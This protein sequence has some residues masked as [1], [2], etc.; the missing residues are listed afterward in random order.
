[1][2]LKFDAILQSEQA[3]YLDRLLPESQEILAE[4]ERFAEENGVPIAD[5]EVA[6]FLEI[7]A[8][9]IRA[10]RCLEIGMAI[11]YGA[12]HLARGI[13]EQGKVFTI[14]PSD[15]MIALGENYL[16]KLNLREKVEIIKGKALDIMPNIEGK[17]DLLY[18]D[19]VKEEYAEYLELG[20][21][22]LRAGG[23]VIADNLLWGGRVAGEIEDEKQ[24]ASTFALRN[25]NEIFVNHPQLKAQILSIGDG[26]GYGVK[27]S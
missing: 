15:Q 18:L 21:P 4:M 26:L 8:R 16:Q 9:A 17:F 3:E 23:I 19:A 27:I 2:K 20:L 22:L 11:G 24:I 7:T 25:F 1:M 10:E 5:R 6:W 13:S 14:E 12:A